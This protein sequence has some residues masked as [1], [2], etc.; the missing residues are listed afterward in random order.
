MQ[1][2]AIAAPLGFVAA[3]FDG[4]VLL[5]DQRDVAAVEQMADRQKSNTAIHALDASLHPVEGIERALFVV[6]R[7]EG[8]D[9]ALACDEVRVYASGKLELHPLPGAMRSAISP[10][11]AWAR[12]ADDIAFHCPAGRLARLMPETHDDFARATA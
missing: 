10:I 7:H 2:K 8:G 4:V 6:L 12:I 3:R 9:F 11:E 5:L 1:P